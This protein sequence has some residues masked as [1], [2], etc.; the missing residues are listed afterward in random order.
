[1]GGRFCGY[2]LGVIIKLDYVSG[3]FLCISGSYLKDK[4]HNGGIFWGC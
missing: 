3:P 1:M 2:F 4:V